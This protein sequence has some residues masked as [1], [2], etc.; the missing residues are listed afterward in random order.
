[1]SFFQTHQLKSLPQ[2]GTRVLLLPLSLFAMV[3]IQQRGKIYTEAELDLAK[4]IN[5]SW[6]LRDSLD[7][8]LDHSPLFTQ[9]GSGSRA[10][11]IDPTTGEPVALAA[12]NTMC[13][14]LLRCELIQ[15]SV[16]GAGTEGS[17]ESS[18]N[19]AA[20]GDAGGN[21]AADKVD[22][23]SSAQMAIGDGIENALHIVQMAMEPGTSE[24]GIRD[25]I[26]EG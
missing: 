6:Q 25:A 21:S 10:G 15:S 11:E 12:A 16:R 17:S 3:L 13:Q 23:S 14:Y 24:Q 20:A 4:H 26:V 18:S 7:S 8:V 1:M 9:Y 5:P 2:G 19:A 22:F